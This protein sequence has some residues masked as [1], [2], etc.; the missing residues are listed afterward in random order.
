MKLEAM[1][2]WISTNQKYNNTHYF[3][4]KLFCTGGSACNSPDKCK[5]KTTR[6][7]YMKQR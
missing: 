6:G 7:I 5:K 4:F 3:I 1:T 2:K